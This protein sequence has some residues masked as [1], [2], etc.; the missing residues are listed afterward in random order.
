MKRK[1]EIKRK[2]RSLEKK[3]KKEILKKRYRKRKREG[4][5]ID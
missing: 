4:E 5:I 1:K 2:N 3:R